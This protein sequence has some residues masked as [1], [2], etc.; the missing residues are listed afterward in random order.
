M[1]VLLYQTGESLELDLDSLIGANFEGKNWHRIIFD[2]KIL[3]DC[4]FTN[5]SLR[6]SG[7]IGADLS[8]AKLQGA[9]LMNA[10][11]HERNFNRL[12]LQRCSASRC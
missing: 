3:Q 2:G 7:F 8:N 5:S 1:I 4:N 12:R 10:L 9:L 11:F 6:N